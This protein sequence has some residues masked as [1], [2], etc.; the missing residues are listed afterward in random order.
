MNGKKI[1]IDS[2]IFVNL[3]GADRKKKLFAS[4][5]PKQTHIISTQVVNENVN[6]CIRKL[7]LSKTEAFTHGHYLM[8]NFLL[9][10]ISR[11]TI[12]GAF[13][14][15]AEYGYSFWDS[16]IISS[17]IENGCNTLYSEDMQHGQIIEKKLK[18]VNPF[19]KD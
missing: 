9:V 13:D 19:S 3:F 10:Q 18:I 14:I 7:K 1:F 15:S 11:S 16:L 4:S 5:L 12:E 2:N 17:A 8:D 6:V